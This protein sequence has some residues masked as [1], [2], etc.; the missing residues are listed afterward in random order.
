MAVAF[1][2]LPYPTLKIGCQIAEVDHIL[3]HRSG[4]PE[5]P[6]HRPVD[7]RR[8]HH[9]VDSSDWSYILPAG[10][11]ESHQLEQGVVGPHAE[12][13]HVEGTHVQHSDATQAAVGNIHV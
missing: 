1:Y 5:G 13:V 8:H 6:S 7:S 4:L 2:F 11:I 10:G 9:A 12:E 3:C